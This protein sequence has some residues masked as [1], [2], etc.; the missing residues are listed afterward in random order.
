MGKLRDWNPDPD[1]VLV[2]AGA[3]GARDQA[4]KY[5]VYHCQN[6]RSLRPCKWIA[7]YAKGQ[8]DTLAEIASPPEDGVIIADLPEFQALA[9]AMP[10]SNGNPHEPHTLVR[11]AK[12]RSVGPVKNDTL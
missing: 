10:K 6:G 4:L 8:I 9:E 7:F 3:A 5:S 1:L 12:V 2:V 11:L